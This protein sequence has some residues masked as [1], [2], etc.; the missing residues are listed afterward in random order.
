[1]TQ[2]DLGWLDTKI[3]DS[4]WLRMT[5]DSTEHSLNESL[6]VQIIQVYRYSSFLRSVGSWI[7]DIK[8]LG[9]ILERDHHTVYSVSLKETLFFCLF[10]FIVVNWTRAYVKKA[11]TD[12]KKSSQATADIKPSKIKKT[13]QIKLTTSRFFS[14][15]LYWKSRF[16]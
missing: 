13:P 16:Q 1:M 6:W 4:K 8:W 14:E 3:N 11:I 9:D 2:D 5:K 7:P 12:M 10:V 15:V